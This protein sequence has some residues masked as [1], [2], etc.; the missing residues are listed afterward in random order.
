MDGNTRAAAM[1]AAR[2]QRIPTTRYT[3][4]FVMLAAGA[5]V[6][7]ALDIGSLGVI[8]PVIHNLMH[9][10]PTDI[11]ALAASSALGI[12]IGMVPCGYFADRYGR[13]RLLIAGVLWF[14]GGTMLSAFSPNFTVLL[15]LRGLCGLGMAPAFIMPYSLVSEFVSATT[16][17]AFASLLETA[18][19][20]GYILP[21]LLAFLIIPA[22]P[23]ELSWRVFLFVAGL[24]L[25]YIWLIW[26]Y[27]PESPRWLSRVGETGRA[28]EI[29]ARLEA[30][31][32]RL[33]GRPLPAPQIG[34]E[35]DR[36]MRVEAMPT[37][38]SL[39]IVWRPPYLAR[40]IAMMC[41]AIGTF[42]M[43]YVTVN[44]I[45]SLLVAHHIALASA[46]L[47]TLVITAA[48]IPWKIANGLLAEH[49]GRK[50][51][52]II[53]M[54]LAAISA[55]RFGFATTPLAMVLWGMMLHSA[56]GA[57]PAYKMWYAE[58]YP[59][60]IRA[61][62]Q[63]TVEAIGGRLVG[64]VVWTFLFP[65]LLA[66]FGLKVT[67]DISAG[68]GLLG[69]VVVTLFAPETFR[70]TVESIESELAAE[71]AGTSPIAVPL[72]RRRPAG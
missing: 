54:G 41:G 31:T 49:I 55:W 50:K 1:L 12:V 45:P 6:I 3:W 13:K 56:S 30:R 26:K 20:I 69:L 64:G 10:T 9:L 72:E 32:E 7:E 39:A 61:I 63:S 18:L 70:R 51:V 53:F 65:S 71:G 59:T 33:L 62:G 29:V 17:S 47:F 37:W 19:G 40:T 27:L 21:P 11:G 38:R 34:E 44:Y 8:L 60:R 58:Q 22:L 42:S 68:V 67:M 66:A 4:L 16:R 52:Y 57:A 43:F 48:Q 35:T 14:A 46:F 2:L 23:A 5:L 36:A 28:E 15:I 25:L 24:P